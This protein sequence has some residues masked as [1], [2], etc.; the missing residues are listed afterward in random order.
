MPESMD[1]VA[2][3]LLWQKKKNGICENGLPYSLPQGLG[4]SGTSEREKAILCTG[5][6][7]Y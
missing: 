4:V 7:S 6:G 2:D 3:Y 1:D 5:R